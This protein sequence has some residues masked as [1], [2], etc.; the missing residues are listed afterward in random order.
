MDESVNSGCSALHLVCPSSHNR[1]LANCETF[2]FPFLECLV[3][4]LSMLVLG[5][6]GYFGI[7]GW[8]GVNTVAELLRDD[9]GD[10][11]CGHYER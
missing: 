6:E 2:E 8:D 9:F 1:H 4:F 10:H 11:W 5:G 7:E 3:K